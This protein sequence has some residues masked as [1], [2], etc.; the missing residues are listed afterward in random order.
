MAFVRLDLNDVEGS[1]AIV[2]KAIEEDWWSERIDVI[3]KEKERITK[4][5]NFFKKV[6]DI[7]RAFE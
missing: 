1:I 6:E 4:D 7:I 2:K 3:R 5:L